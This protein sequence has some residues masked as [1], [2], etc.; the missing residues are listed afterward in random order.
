M[1]RPRS[2]RSELPRRRTTPGFHHAAHVVSHVIA[3]ITMRLDVQGLEH[4]PLQGGFVGAANHLS[5][6]D[7]LV[8]LAVMPIRPG[9]A[10]TAIEH[11]HDFFVGWVLDRLGVIWID[12]DNPS[13]DALR[14][15]LNEMA[16]GT[17]LGIAPE[18]TRSRTVGLLSGKTG[19][20]Y[21]A[22]RAGVPIFPAA[23]WGTEKVASNLRRLRRTTVHFHMGEPIHL[24][25]GRA[26]TEEL[27]E[28]TELLMRRIASMLPPEYRGVYAD[29][30]K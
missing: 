10:F 1:T 25:Q 28:Y 20:A 21:L 9:T 2:S 13:R 17:A 18:G 5:S 11:R 6:F 8:V 7:P 27:E 16:L 3:K 19:A 22:T 15:A 14:I 24:P 30:V 26:G 23:I 4:I 29:R 12:R